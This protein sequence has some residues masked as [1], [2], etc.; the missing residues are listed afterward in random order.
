MNLR[1]ATKAA[2][3][4]TQDD[5][6]AAV[7]WLSRQKPLHTILLKLGA[8]QAV[9][10]YFSDQRASAMA[11]AVGRVAATANNPN[12]AKSVAA[13]LA[14]NAFWDSYTLFGMVS[15]KTATQEQLLASAGSREQHGRGELRLARFE[16]AVAAQLK[17]PRSVVCRGMSLST[18]E[19]LA[20]KFGA[21]Q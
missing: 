18:L 21:G 16:R 13:R 17:S 15:I 19:R 3:A 10:D 4:A 2:L 12:A 20:A 5:P 9:R 11:R 1:R 6:K 7:A 8:R 14:R